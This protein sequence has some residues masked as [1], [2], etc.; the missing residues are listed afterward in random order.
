M[1][2]G[3]ENKRKA[4][5]PIERPLKIKAPKAASFKGF[6]DFLDKKT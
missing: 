2:A 4:Q 3:A 5:I 6:E 1:E